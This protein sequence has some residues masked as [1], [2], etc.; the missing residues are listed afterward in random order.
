MEDA[1]RSEHGAQ[2]D[3]D[4]P[5]LRESMRVS[6]KLKKSCLLFVNTTPWLSRKNKK[7]VFL[8]NIT[9]LLD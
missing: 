1:G 8:T 7:E 2:T 5:V 4:S 9:V 3:M 6:L